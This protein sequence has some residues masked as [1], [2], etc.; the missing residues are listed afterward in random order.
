MHLDLDEEQMRASEG[1]GL[2]QLEDH[3]GVTS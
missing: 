3:C 2:T 1:F